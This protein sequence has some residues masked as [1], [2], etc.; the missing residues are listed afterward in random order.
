MFDEK[1]LYFAVCGTDVLDFH[2]LKKTTIYDE[3]YSEDCQTIQ[4]FWKV[5]LE[6]FTT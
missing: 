4:D 2:E 5:L 6:D 3:G 1:D